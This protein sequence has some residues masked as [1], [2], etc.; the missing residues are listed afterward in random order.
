VTGRGGTSSGPP[1]PFEDRQAL[2]TF[3]ARLLA[4]LRQPFRSPADFFD[5]IARGRSPL[6][7]WRCLVALT[8]PWQ[9]CLLLL[10]LLLAA[11][12]TALPPGLPG[13][14]PPLV[15]RLAAGCLGLGLALPLLQALALV[16]DALLVHGLL[17]LWGVRPRPLVQILR[18]LGYTRALAALAGPLP[19][20]AL[21]ARLGSTLLLAWGLARLHGTRPWRCLGALL[22]RLLLLLCGLALLGVLLV[23]YDQRQ[24]QIT[25]PSDPAP[26]SEPPRRPSPV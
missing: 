26:E 14:A 5:G 16:L 20:L 4:T 18:A 23:R 6:A 24:R 7:P 8:L 3:P 12:G 10:G 1:C 21:L 2:P 11:A 15:W 25:L 9:A 13:E 17:R 22:T 19:P